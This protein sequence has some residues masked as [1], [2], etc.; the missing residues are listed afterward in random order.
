MSV[1]TRAVIVPATRRAAAVWLGAALGGVLV[2]GGNGIPP[3]DLTELALH[4]PIVAAVLVGTWTLLF[5]PTARVLLRQPSAH[6][7]RSLPG[8]RAAPVIAMLAALVALQ[9]PWL[10]L[11]IVGEGVRGLA[12]VAATTVPLAAIAAFPVR[13]PRASSPRW[14]TLVGALTGVYARALRRRAGHAIVRGVGLSI[15]AGLVGGLVARNNQLEGASAA[16]IASATIAIVL[17]P[18]WAGA[19]LPLLEAHRSSAWLASTLGASERA[20][21]AVLAIAVAGVYVTG[22]I[23]AAIATAFVA[24]PSPWLGLV[25]A[26]SAGA[27]LVATRALVWAERAP[28]KTA[29]RAVVGAFAASAVAVLALGVLGAAGVPALAACGMIA[30]ATVKT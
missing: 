1:W 18:G 21:I 8:P 26:T 23:I 10:V 4:V 2:F 30:I 24:T 6:Y 16:T 7:L 13:P 19:L 29:A 17:V 27:A 9:I 12:V 25:V 11:W 15:L 22:G 14:K 5:V 28:D 20:R 3:H